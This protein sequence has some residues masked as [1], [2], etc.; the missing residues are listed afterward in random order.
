MSDTAYL[1]LKNALA[2]T[3][4]EG[5]IVTKQTENDCTRLMRGEV[6]VAELVKEILSRPVKAG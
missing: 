1:E 2:S 5:Y 3:R 6:S 4:M